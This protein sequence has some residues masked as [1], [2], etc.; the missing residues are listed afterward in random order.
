MEQEAEPEEAVALVPAQNT[1]LE[2]LKEQN[3]DLNRLLMQEQID[4]KELQEELESNLKLKT[5]MEEELASLQH[6][7]LKQRGQSRLAERE[8]CLSA[9]K[10]SDHLHKLTR[11]LPQNDVFGPHITGMQKEAGPHI[12]Y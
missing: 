11:A 5:E 9:I 7:N 10:T 1:E 6:E 3:R 2:N 8:L 12:T 4:K